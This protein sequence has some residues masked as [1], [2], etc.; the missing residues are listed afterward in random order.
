MGSHIDKNT[1][2]W[3]N[4]ELIALEQAK[5]SIFDHGLLYGDGIFEGLRF[6]NGQA[7][8]AR[9]H[10]KRLS[11]SA[12]AIDLQLP[13]DDDALLQGLNAAIGAYTHN[14]G[15]IRILVTRGEGNLGL[16]PKR[17]ERAN[18]FIVVTELELMSPE[19]QAEGL[20][21]IT[22]AT[23]RVSGTGLDSRVKSLNYLHSILA[24]TEANH[25]GAD[26]ALLLNAQGLVA[27]CSAA[28]IFIVKDGALY[29]PPCT[30]GALEG[31]TRET[32]I[33][34]ACSQGIAVH[35]QSL[36]QWDIY[37]ADECFV[38]GSAA[39]LISVATLDGRTTGHVKGPVFTV[40]RQ[41]FSESVLTALG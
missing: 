3:H 20:S 31:I 23:R 24:K 15:Y 27:E 14:E 39:R 30:D 13:Y 35:K 8:K 16:D 28:N 41:L 26:D 2:C 7:F 18:V 32:V 33:E 4:G 21:L 1:V 6:Y 17:C 25:A 34:L 40:L 11:E 5:V 12:K 38:T 10:L 19:R 9:R 37:N 22:A 29:T 36:T